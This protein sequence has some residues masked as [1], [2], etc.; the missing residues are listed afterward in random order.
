MNKFSDLVVAYHRQ[1]S[2]IVNKRS[3]KGGE[4]DHLNALRKAGRPFTPRGPA[5]KRLFK[6]EVR[7]RV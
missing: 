5:Y 4:F 7:R 1:A 6:L 2:N 3:D